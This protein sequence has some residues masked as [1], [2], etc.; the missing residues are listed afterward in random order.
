[1][2][3]KLFKNNILKSTLYTLS[4]KIAAMMF[5]MAFDIACARILSPEDYAEWVFFFAVLTMMFYIGWCGINTSAK[6]FISKESTQ[7]GIS[8]KIKAS[9]LLR[10][11][12]SILIGMLL[13]ILAHPL[14]RWLGYPDKYP[15][16]YCLCI[17]AGLLV[18][19]NSYSE[20]FKEVFM[21]LGEFKRLCLITILEFAGYF[22]FS[23]I[24][25]IILKKVEA[26]AF[27]YLCSGIG[28]F[29]FGSICLKQISATGL[30]PRKTD[31]FC[32]DM[33]KIFRYAIPIAIS[34]IG[35]MVLV[36]MDTFM[37]GILST[38]SQVANY[39]IA[40]NLCAKA[41]H[42]N[43]ALT[44]GSMTSFSVLT[45]GN[46]KEKR[47]RFMKT[48]NMN[49]L[50]SVVIAGMFL[51]LGT[52]MIKVL[53]GFEYQEAGKILKYLVPYYVMYGISSFFATFLDFQGKAKTR[54]ICYCTVVGLNLGLNLLLIPQLGAVGAAI[55]TSLSLVPYTILVVVITGKVIKSY[56]K[57]NLNNT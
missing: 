41:T 12:A 23:F 30:L 11:L 57:C 35:G 54:S 56:S 52:F 4:G 22:F 6:V 32:F 45:I 20:F 17:F 9:F 42:I 36:E 10:L 1:M 48:S 26:A 40:K 25:L 5:Y 2:I 29:L 55:A 18:F 49:I 3:E 37:L 34:S 28:V 39:G 33:N 50:I 53:Y 43:Y 8:K 44:V 21:G 15:D 51:L 13:T 14:A 27:G 16:L 47:S 7:E 46:I 24:F 31:D 38:K 19:F